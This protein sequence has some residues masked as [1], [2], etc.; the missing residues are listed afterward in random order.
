MGALGQIG[1]LEGRVAIVTGGGWGFGPAISL[2]LARE[3]ADVV[4]VDLTLPPIREVAS[5]ITELG[6]RA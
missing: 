1:K 6:R 3:G 5:A 2:A 4:L